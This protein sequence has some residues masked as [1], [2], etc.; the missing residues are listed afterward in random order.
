MLGEKEEFSCG[1]PSLTQLDNS[2]GHPAQHS[3]LSMP[4]D[5]PP[6]T[7]RTSGKFK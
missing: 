7:Q 4:R 2:A 5:R 6:I 3:T 1:G